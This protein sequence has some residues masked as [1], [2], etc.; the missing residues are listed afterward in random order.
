MIYFYSSDIDF[1][2]LKYINEVDA[3]NTY[4]LV[5]LDWDT[6]VYSMG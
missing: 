2:I 3:P 6:F 1:D 5:Y 4:Y